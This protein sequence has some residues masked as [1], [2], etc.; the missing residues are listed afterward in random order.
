MTKV[1]V[2]IPS[3]SNM[4]GLQRLI[5]QLL[6]DPSVDEIVVVADGPEAYTRI[7]SLNLP[8]TL[9]QVPL[10][11]GIHVM[12]NLG[13]NHVVHKKNNICFINDDVSLGDLCMSHLS[14]FLDNNKEYGLVTPNFTGHPIESV[15]NTTAFAGFC[16]MLSSDLCETFR[17][18]ERMK[19]WYGDNDIITWVSRTA[20]RLTGIVGSTTCADNQSFT[21]RHDPPPNFYQLILEDAR[22]YK[23]K[24]N[25]E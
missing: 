4:P 20:N 19:W 6:S 16:M 1:D 9:L 23:E 15:Y 11:V 18:D 3:K 7:S 5:S 13:I 25:I 10:S 17:F 22:L 14:E 24:W 8:I 2:V 12:W 21:I